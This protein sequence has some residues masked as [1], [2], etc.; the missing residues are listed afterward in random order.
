MLH[1]GEGDIGTGEVALAPFRALDLTDGSGWFCGK[2]LADLGADVIKVEPPGGERGRLLGP[3]ADD[4]PDPDRALPW[5]AGNAGKRGIT[6]NLDVPDGQQV[7]RCLVERADCVVESSP[8]GWMAERGL[9]YE[10]LSGRN[11]RLVVTSITPFGQGGPRALWRA[12]DLELMAASGCMMLAG[13]PDGPPVRISLPQS[14]CWAG[15]AAAMGTLIAHHYRMA[16]GKGQHV[17]VSGQASLL[18]ALSHAPTFWDLN[19][20][21]QRRAGPYLTGRTITG[22]RMR[23]IWP[24]RDGYVTFTIY[25][26]VAGR[27]TNQQLVA[28]MIERDMAPDFLRAMDWERFEVATLTQEEANRLEGAIGKFLEGLTK[29]EFFEEVMARGMLGYPVATAEDI[30]A[31]PHLEDRDFWQNIPH[32]ALGRPLRMPGAFAKPAESPW[33]PLRP[34][35]RIG[36]HNREIYQGELGLT[37]ERLTRWRDDHVV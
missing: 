19:R 28:W 21:P 36:E 15:L 35:P 25:G 30:L 13:E 10:A 2:I 8:P 12:S 3:F 4:V 18:W 37:E 23:T 27:H 20:E 34:A 7:F 22:A 26:G 14:P 17:D 16:T 11:P 6:L 32:P 9:G 33:S 31:D 1:T 24:C 29:T 5:L